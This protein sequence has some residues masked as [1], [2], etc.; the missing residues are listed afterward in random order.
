MQTD[1]GQSKIIKK[2]WLL[3]LLEEHL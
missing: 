2:S 3:I 1:K